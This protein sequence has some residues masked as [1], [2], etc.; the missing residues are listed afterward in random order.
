MLS[1]YSE[2]YRMPAHSQALQLHFK[3]FN[4]NKK[5]SRETTNDKLHKDVKINQVAALY[6]SFSVISALILYKSCSRMFGVGRENDQKL[7]ISEAAQS[8]QTTDEMQLAINAIMC[9]FERG[10]MESGRRKSN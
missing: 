2:I 7:A 5:Y 1:S 9:R 10:K 8:V 6:S 3:R 4:V